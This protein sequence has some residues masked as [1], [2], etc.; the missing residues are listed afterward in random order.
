VLVGV[1][2]L[3]LWEPLLGLR[4]IFQEPELNQR[5]SKRKTTGDATPWRFIYRSLLNMKMTI[6]VP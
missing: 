5:K 6:L 3:K 1:H 4:L 2:K